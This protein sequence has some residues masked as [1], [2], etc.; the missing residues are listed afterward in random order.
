MY[1]CMYFIILFPFKKLYVSKLLDEIGLG[2]TQNDTYRLV[3]TLQEKVIDDNITL[4]RK[5]DWSKVYCC[6]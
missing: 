3:K 4:S 5:F 1:V 6:I 2:G